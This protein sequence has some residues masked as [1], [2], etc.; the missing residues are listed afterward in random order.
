MGKTGMGKLLQKWQ[1]SVCSDKLAWWRDLLKLLDIYK[2]LA[3]ALPLVNM[4]SF[5]TMFGMECCQ[6]LNIL[7]STP[8]PR[9]NVF[10][11]K[12]QKQWD[13][14]F[15]RF[16]M[17]LSQMKLFCSSQS[18]RVTSLN[19]QPVQKMIDGFTYGGRIIILVPEHKQ[20]KGHMEV[21]PLG[22]GNRLV[23]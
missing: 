8:L 4:C 2:G 7:N 19:H 17:F 14:I 3:S 16:S 1:A 21:H 15:I 23:S 18:L 11:C 13:P 6:S 9:I 22:C 10:P 5:G 12:R 20:L